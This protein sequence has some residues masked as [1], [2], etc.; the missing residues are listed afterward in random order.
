MRSHN[1]E[2]EAKGLLVVKLR[3][4]HFQW[5]SCTH[6]ERWREGRQRGEREGAF[7]EEGEEE[8]H[9]SLSSCDATTQPLRVQL[10]H[11]GTRTRP[12]SFMRPHRLSERFFCTSDTSPPVVPTPIYH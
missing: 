10:C 2:E 12:L 6:A 7:V 8:V 1:E 9:A 4:R 3:G 11:Y 5:H